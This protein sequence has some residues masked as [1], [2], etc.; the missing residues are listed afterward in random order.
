[1][2]RLYGFH[3]VKF[4]TPVENAAWAV[5]TQRMPIPIA[6]RVKNAIVERYGGSVSVGGRAYPAFPEARTLAAV[7]L[8]DLQTLIHNERK[9]GYLL[10]VARAF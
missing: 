10:A 3:Q 9:T 5:L 4:M 2:R 7:P 8:A 6:R 1:M